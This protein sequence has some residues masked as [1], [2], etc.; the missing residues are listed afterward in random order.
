MTIAYISICGKPSD[1]CGGTKDGDDEGAS[2]RLGWDL[3]ALGRSSEYED[4]PQIVMLVNQE[5]ESSTSC[6]LADPVS[7]P[8]DY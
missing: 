1:L 8:S 5:K 7:M 4:T 3:T 2:T 6:S